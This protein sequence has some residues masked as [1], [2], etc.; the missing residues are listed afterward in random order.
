MRGKSKV[1]AHHPT[2]CPL[3]K[4]AIPGGLGG[5]DEKGISDMSTSLFEFLD[6]G[7]R[8]LSGVAGV[9]EKEVCDTGTSAN[10]KL[11]VEM[12][13][14]NG[15]LDICRVGSLRGQYSLRYNQNGVRKSGSLGFEI[16]TTG[17]LPKCCRAVLV[18][19]RA[20]S[21]S[22]SDLVL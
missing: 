10:G 7:T 19:L 4:R 12:S 22:L 14:F 5:F 11:T 8:A 9:C 18:A 3:S 17:R 16:L 13:A 1:L 15:V 20:V 6:T 2:R 21:Y